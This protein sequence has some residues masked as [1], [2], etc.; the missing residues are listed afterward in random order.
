M[1]PVFLTA[2]ISLVAGPG[3][4]QDIWDEPGGI[5]TAGAVAL[6]LSYS[7]GGRDRLDYHLRLGGEA[8]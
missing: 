2:L 8:N 5:E 6:G 4:A 1:K 3:L 7:G